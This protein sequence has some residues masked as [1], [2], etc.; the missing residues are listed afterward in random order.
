MGLGIFTARWLPTG[1][2]KLDG[3]AR[4]SFRREFGAGIAILFAAVPMRATF[5]FTCGMGVF[6]VG[7]FVVLLPLALRDLYAGGARAISLGFM[8]FG[9]GTLTS[10]VG[11]IRADEIGR[12]ARAPSCSTA[13]AWCC[14]RSRWRRRN[15][16]STCASSSGAWGA[17]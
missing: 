13:G 4:G 17:A 7:V 8:A 12:P 11:L 15:W 1:A 9:A 16:C 10:I 2:L 5:L 6:F 14:C 3:A